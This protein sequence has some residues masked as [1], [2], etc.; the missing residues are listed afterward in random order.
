[1]SGR[2]RFGWLVVLIFYFSGCA[3][4]NPGAFP[5]QSEELPA[6]PDEEQARVVEVGFIV[7]LKLISGEAV[8]G[9]VVEVTPD[10]IVFGKAGNYGLEKQI[11]ARSEIQSM[12]IRDE[13][14]F[15]KGILIT[16]AVVFGVL[17]ALAV[18]CALSCDM[19]GGY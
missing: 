15:S 8:E 14:G 4:Y 17:G 7:E 2:G 11:Y 16:F 9:T 18:L 10:Q 19:G 13:A 5:M 3:H 6:N 1:M 12:E